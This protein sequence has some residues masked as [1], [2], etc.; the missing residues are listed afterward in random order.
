LDEAIEENDSNMEDLQVVIT[1]MDAEIDS[2][3]MTR[4][5]LEKLLQDA[6]KL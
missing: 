6:G 2:L 4:E 5:N 3:I 1:K